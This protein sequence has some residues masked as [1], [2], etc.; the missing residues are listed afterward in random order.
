MKVEISDGPVHMRLEDGWPR[1]V[2]IHVREDSV[3][4]KAV[5]WPKDKHKGAAYVALDV[6]ANQDSAGDDASRVDVTTYVSIEQ[7]ETMRDSLSAALEEARDD[8]TEDGGD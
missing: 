2:G 7:A 5:Y 6:N 4:I 3:V 1:T 8:H